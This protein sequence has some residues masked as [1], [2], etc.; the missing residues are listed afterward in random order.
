MP[1]PPPIPFA[2]GLHADAMVTKKFGQSRRKTGQ[3]GTATHLIFVCDARRS[4]RS[5]PGLLTPRAAES[6]PAREWNCARRAGALTKIEAGK[7]TKGERKINLI[8]EDRNRPMGGRRAEMNRG[9]SRVNSGFTRLIS[10]ARLFS[11]RA[12][13]LL[14]RSARSARRGFAFS[15]ASTALSRPLPRGE[16]PR[17]CA[18]AG[19]PDAARSMRWSRS[20]SSRS[21]SPSWRGRARTTPAGT[22]RGEKA[23]LEGRAGSSVAGREAAAT[24]RRYGARGRPRRGWDPGTGSERSGREARG[25]GTRTRA[26][27]NRAEGGGEVGAQKRAESVALEERQTRATTRLDGR[28]L[29]SARGG[30]RGGAGNAPTAPARPR[31]GPAA[32]GAKRATAPGR[33]GRRRGRGRRRRRGLPVAVDRLGK[34]FFA[35]RRSLVPANRARRRAVCAARPAAAT[36]SASRWGT[37]ARTSMS[38]GCASSRKPRLS[39]SDESGQK[40][41]RRRRRR[42][43]RPEMKSSRRRTVSVSA[44]EPFLERRSRRRRRR[45]SR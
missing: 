40:A 39:R 30:G 33:P 8:G 18:R 26:F 45:R 6:G 37:A 41:E 9:L 3:H 11:P 25:R 34:R 7:K 1:D 14:P 17:R 4:R 20:W 16:A 15:R 38:P 2:P 44:R 13:Q 10:A 31:E 35:S 27:G 12:L 21:W 43:R 24:T 19:G 36:P 23:S 5:L 32:G 42:R 28:H 22:R 29:F